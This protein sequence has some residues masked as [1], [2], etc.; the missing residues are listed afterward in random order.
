MPTIKRKIKEK[1]K[2]RE[3]IKRNKYLIYIIDNS[4]FCI[5]KIGIPF[6]MYRLLNY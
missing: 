3:N 4:L 5:I 6:L 2:N 1:L